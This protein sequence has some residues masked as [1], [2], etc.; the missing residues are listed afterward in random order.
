MAVTVTYKYPVSG[1]TPPTIAQS[2]TTNAVVASVELPEADTI[3]LVTHNFQTSTAELAFLSPWVSY[4][5]TFCG[6]LA[7]TIVTT[8]TN[9]VVVTITKSA[10]VGTA[11]TLTVVIQRPFSMIR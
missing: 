5:S 11:T 7:A 4:V 2:L 3:A 1:T 8:L 9:S 10:A 6:T